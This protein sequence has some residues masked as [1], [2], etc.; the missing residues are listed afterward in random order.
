MHTESKTN[1]NSDKTLRLIFPEWQG[2]VN[3]KLSP[4]NGNSET[5]EVP[6]DKNYDRELKLEN[7]GFFAGKVLCKQQTE[8]RKILI[9]KAPKR[10]ITFGG[11]CSVSQAPF[12]YLHKIYP[13]NLGILWIDAHPDIST[14]KDFMHEHA[15][16]LGNLLGEG[17]P[18]LAKLVENP[19]KP[20]EVIYAGLK[21]KDMQEYEKEYLKNKGMRYVEPHDLLDNSSI[22]LS[23]IKENKIEKVVVHFDMDVLTAN[24]FRSLLYNEPGIGE[25]DYA[26]GSMTL[27]NVVRVINDVDQAAQVVGLTIAEYIP[28][29]LINLKKAME[30]LKIFH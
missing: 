23:W 6:V 9:E 7:G 10:V 24:D 4:N 2:G 30:G 8:A 26:T 13:E 12:D 21:A 16:V 1:V 17:A 19:F 20:S 3:P 25:V 11:D 5:I 18:E 27:K 29:D 28:W 14:P 22:L 15:M